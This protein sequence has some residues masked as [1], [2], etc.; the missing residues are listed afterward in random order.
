MLSVWITASRPKTLVAT[1]AP[2]SLGLCLSLSEGIFHPLLFIVTLLTGL[3]IQIGTN[4]TNDY[5]DFI[6]GADTADRKGFLRV[7]QAGL[8]S[9]ST[10]KKGIIALFALSL[11]LGSY[12]A[13]IGGAPIALLLCLYVL[14]GVLYTAGPYPLGYLGMGDVLVFLFYGPMSTLITYYLQTSHLSWQ[15]ILVGLSIGSLSTAILAI[16]NI[17]DI[18]EDRKAGKKTLPVRFG[19]KWGQSEFRFLVLFAFLPPLFLLLTHPFVTLTLLSL[20]QALVLIRAVRRN[21][22][23]YALNPLFEKM[24]KL[25]WLFTFLL[26]LGLLI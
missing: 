25:L 19:R 18:E 11:L 10:M 22:D 9:A 3:C 8:V 2:A 14:L 20:P 1:F 13:A 26:I 4:F 17:R 6:K 23:P 21:E 24:G 16:N 15:P 7:T 12:L 5:C